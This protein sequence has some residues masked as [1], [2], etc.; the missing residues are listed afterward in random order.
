MTTAEF[1]NNRFLLLKCVSGSRAYGL[2]RPE[3]DV[4]IRGVFVLPKRNFYGLDYAEQVNDQKNDVIFY[5]LKKFV[6]L[7]AKNNPNI[8]ELLL[9]PED[10]TQYRHILTERLK[11][12]LFISKLCR[13]TF[14]GYAISQIKR[15]RG[16]NK[17]IVKPMSKKRKSVLDFCYVSRGNASIP[18]R[19]FLQE[20]QWE[21]SDCGLAKIP[22]MKGMYA[23]YHEPG[24]GYEGIVRANRDAN[25]IALSSISKG[26]PTLGL[27]YFNK[28]GYSVYCKEYKEYWEWVEK[29]NEARYQSTMA[30]GKRYDAKNMMH[31]FRLLHMAEE[32]ATKGFFSVRRTKDRDFLLGVRRGD[33]EYDDLVV[34]AEEKIKQID[35]LFEKSR[36]PQKPD[37]AKINQVL[38]DIRTAFYNEGMNNE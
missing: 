38:V 29:R 16:L 6:S 35:D 13:H 12:E 23:L 14:A 11:P 28:D 27:L 25:D 1:E 18:L 9:T 7:L 37:R 20:N 4:D 21:Q 34:Q 26:A 31:T 19:R 5:E 10:C 24:A 22:H 30:H 8:L 36:L 2:D 17:K 33:F 3:S 15:A 32:I